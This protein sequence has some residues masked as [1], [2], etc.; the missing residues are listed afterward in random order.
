MMALVEA[1][2]NDHEKY[3]KIFKNI[4]D[5]YKLQENPKSLTKKQILLCLKYFLEKDE[6]SGKN[7]L[8]RIYYI[9]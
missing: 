6:N 1:Y 7:K 3:K 2:M 4:G 5:L 9:S 8:Y